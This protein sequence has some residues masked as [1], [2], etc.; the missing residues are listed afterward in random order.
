[1]VWKAAEKKRGRMGS[2]GGAGEEEDGGC[3]SSYPLSQ[4]RTSFFAAMRYQNEEKI[5]RGPR[6][7]SVGLKAPPLKITRK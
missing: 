2:G 1:M 6:D 5:T 7:A 4:R 3:V